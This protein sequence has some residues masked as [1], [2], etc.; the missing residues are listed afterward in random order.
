MHNKYIIQTSSTPYEF[1]DRHNDLVVHVTDMK[2]HRYEIHDKFGNHMFI[3]CDTN[4]TIN[5]LIVGTLF[6]PYYVLYLL[7]IDEDATILP[8][9]VFLTY[10]KYESIYEPMSMEPHQTLLNR[11]FTESF[12]RYI[13]STM[14]FLPDDIFFIQ[15]ATMWYSGCFR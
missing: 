1:F 9:D 8:A 10:L 2:S 7:I 14:D 6:N 5:N 12:K 4:D 11:E 13:E 3:G 15:S